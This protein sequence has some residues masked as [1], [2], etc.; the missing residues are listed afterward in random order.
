M[1]LQFRRLSPWK[2]LPIEN[3]CMEQ[4]KYTRTQFLSS[5]STSEHVWDWL[6]QD[7]QRSL[8]VAIIGNPN[9]GMMYHMTPRES[10]DTICTHTRD[11]LRHT[12]PPYKKDFCA[13]P[14]FMR[15]RQVE[16]VFLCCALSIHSLYYCRIR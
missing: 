14:K 1:L 5:D 12:N 16:R 13:V 11:Y 4:V 3:R 7:Q 9:V 15:M 6:P 8:K 2:L 10:H